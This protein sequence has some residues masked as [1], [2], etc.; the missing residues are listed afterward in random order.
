[1]VSLGHVALD[2]TKRML[3][4]EKEL[5][6]EIN[7]LMRRAEIL[8]AHGDKRY[9][10]GKLGI[11]LPD[12]LR[13]RQDHLARIRQARKGMKA[14]TAAAPSRQ[15]QEE[16]EEA[17]PKA[18]AAR[19]SDAPAAEQTE[20]NSKAETAEAKAKAAR[21]KAA[22]AAEDACLEPPDLEALSC[23][24]MPRCLATIR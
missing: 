12:E 5:E 18:T 8:D 19:E 20:L 2:G 7:A 1:M 15:R 11:D 22:E 10:K 16:A 14:E 6:K 3:W 17:R 24:A 23:E 13:R 21:D 9:G 4:A